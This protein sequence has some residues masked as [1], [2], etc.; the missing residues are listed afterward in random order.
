ME[1]LK[2]TRRLFDI[3]FNTEGAH[4]ALV[5]K[6]QGGAA[7]GHTTL[8]T[9]ATNKLPTVEQVAES[10]TVQKALEQVEVKMSMEEFL[11]KFFDMWHSDAELLTKLMGFETEYEAYLRDAESEPMTHVDYLDSTLSGIS[12]MKSM[13]EGSLESI[14]ET[15]Y[16]TLIKYQKTFENG[17][18][19]NKEDMVSKSLLTDSESKVVE[20]TKSVTTLQTDL[21]KAND[22][23]AEFET[24]E[25]EKSKASRMDTLT[26]VLP[27]D[28]VEVT[29]KSLEALDDDA[30]ATIVKQFKNNFDKESESELFTEKGVDAEVESN[31]A[32]DSSLLKIIKNNKSNKV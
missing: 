29:Y 20:L 4:V 13:S 30:F 21:Q 22:R 5:G 1:K 18:T 19:M 27:E 24:A 28:Q 14:S 6:G 16:L 15:D 12:L 7:N 17:E 10:E 26:G 11:R 9:K 25:V 8:V 31:S 3:D 23:I 32:E 2:A